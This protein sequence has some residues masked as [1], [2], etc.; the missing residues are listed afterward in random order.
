MSIVYLGADH[1]GFRLK[2]E[3]K[4]WFKEWGYEFSDLGNKVYEKDDDYTDVAIKVAEKV[5]TEKAK[6]VV[7]CRTGV[8]VCIAANKVKGIRA[9]LCTSEKQA[10]L[11]RVDDDVNILCLSADN[12]DE[13][14]NRKIV[15]VFL[16]TLFSSEEKHIRRIDKI[17]I[18]EST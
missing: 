7:I 6:G 4:K 1:R 3:I 2:E 9:A 5:V 10:E 16:E 12:V 17:K 14:E 13:E 11:A 15:R 8:G 18:Y